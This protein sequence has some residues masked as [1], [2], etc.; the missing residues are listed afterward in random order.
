MDSAGSSSLPESPQSSVIKELHQPSTPPNTS[1]SPLAVADTTTPIGSPTT[2]RK[3]KRSSSSS[4]RE[5]LFVII[6]A[7]FLF[8]SLNG[9]K[10][11]QSV[12]SQLE[13]LQT[14]YWYGAPPQGESNA[15]PPIENVTEDVAIIISTS[16]IPTCPSTYIIEQVV[17]S[18][19]HFIG[20]SP[21][22]PIFI[23]VDFFRFADFANLPPAL[24]DRIETLEEYTINLHKLYLRNPRIHVISSVKNNHIGGS[25]MKGMKLIE[26][27]FPTVR[28]LHYIQ[29]DFPFTKDID[30]T[31]L[32]Q[33]M[34]DYP[35]VNYVRFGKRHPNTL[36]PGCGDAQPILYNRTV[37]MPNFDGNAT[38]PLKLTPTMAYSDNNHLVRFTWYYK[39]IASLG[40]INRA[41]E[42][43]L[44]VRINKGCRGIGPDGIVG[45]YL[46]H[47]ACIG[48]LDGRHATATD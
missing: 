30:H 4:K 29:H 17:N 18:T 15:K 6:V 3:R 14:D 1:S 21:T 45:L 46:Y 43:P 39:T 24:K 13:Q 31:A 36:H 28:Y 8:N 10:I 48:H 44:N 42:D 19:N 20:L 11:M 27:L 35:V 2:P 7:I 34:D 33:V 16:W 5:T 41:P 25:A 37:G 47:K 32:I 38:W 26:H 12:N 23:T 22:A 40:K 9:R